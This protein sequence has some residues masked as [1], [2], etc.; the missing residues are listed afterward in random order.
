[1]RPGEYPNA[2][3]FSWFIYGNVNNNNIQLCNNN[4]KLLSIYPLKMNQLKSYLIEHEIGRKKESLT[5]NNEVVVDE[6]YENLN[7]NY[8]N[9]S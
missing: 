3:P 5:D 4:T 6:I 1:M 2:I 8:D 9:K 7:K